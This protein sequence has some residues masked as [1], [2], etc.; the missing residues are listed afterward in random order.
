[1][2]FSSTECHHSINARFTD[3]SLDLSTISSR[4]EQVLPAQTRTGDK[5][6]TWGHPVYREVHPDDA[7]WK[8]SWTNPSENLDFILILPFIKAIDYR[9]EIDP[10]TDALFLDYNVIHYHHPDSQL[11]LM[12]TTRRAKFFKSEVWKLL[13]KDGKQIT[14]SNIET[15][16]DEKGN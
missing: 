7:H 10:S 12:S 4:K 14:C 8:R 16:R 1:M 3:R 15:S 5:V 2:K 9:S 13:L 6:P 11:A